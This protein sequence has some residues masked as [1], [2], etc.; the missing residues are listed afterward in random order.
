MEL[1]AES[2]VPSVLSRY[3]NYGRNLTLIAAAVSAKYPRAPSSI[4]VQTSVTRQSCYGTQRTV[5]SFVL[6]VQ[7]A[8]LPFAVQIYKV[9]RE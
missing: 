9:R 3:P 7:S 8:M 2:E 4:S 5:R 1:P 6:K